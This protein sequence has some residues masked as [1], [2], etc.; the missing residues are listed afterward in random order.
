[1]GG[2]LHAAEFSGEEGGVAVRRLHHDPVLP[3]DAHIYNG[4]NALDLHRELRWACR[5]RS[6]SLRQDQHVA[7]QSVTPDS[8]LMLLGAVKQALVWDAWVELVRCSA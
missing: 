4:Q 3:S 8:R 5:H 6:V 2:R 7:R 1:M